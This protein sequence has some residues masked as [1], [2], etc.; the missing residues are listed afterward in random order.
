MEAGAVVLEMKKMTA[1]QPNTHIIPSK[2]HF[3]NE[4]QSDFY[5]KTSFK[6]ISNCLGLQKYFTELII[7][8]HFHTL[9]LLKLFSGEFFIFFMH[10]LVVVFKPNALHFIFMEQTRFNCS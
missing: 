2:I 8:E 10:P 5:K 9:L 4:Q 6:P 3:Y 7:Q 1:K